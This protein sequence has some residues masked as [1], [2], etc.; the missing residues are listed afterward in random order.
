MYLE[1]H[2]KDG[3][4]EEVD[5]G[6]LTA[7]APLGGPVAMTRAW[8]VWNPD[9]TYVLPGTGGERPEP[10][11]MIIITQIEANKHI[12]LAP[13]RTMAQIGLVLA[14]DMKDVV[15]VKR[16]GTPWLIRWEEDGKFV[17]LGKLDSYGKATVPQWEDQGVYYGIYAAHEIYSKTDGKNEM[18]KT[19]LFARRFDVPE[20]LVRQ[21]IALA[22]GEKDAVN[23]AKDYGEGSFG[24]D[25]YE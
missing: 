19:E 20:K 3:R 8:A 18:Q 15:L 4:V 23:E 16:E 6:T 17:D 10:G 11:L 7:N 25:D 12:G 21:A 24:A 1:I 22:T 9:G 5:A 14:E 13:E 2:Y